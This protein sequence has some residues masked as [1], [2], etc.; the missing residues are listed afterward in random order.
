[1]VLNQSTVSIQEYGRTWVSVVHDG[2]LRLTIIRPRV[3]FSPT[4]ALFGRSVV[5]PDRASKRR[6]PSLQGSLKLCFSDFGSGERMTS[7]SGS[8][9]LRSMFT[10]Y[11]AQISSAWRMRAASASAKASSFG[12][13]DKAGFAMT[14]ARPLINSRLISIAF[15]SSGSSAS[16]VLEGPD[17]TD[18]ADV[19]TLRAEEGVEVETLGMIELDRHGFV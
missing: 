1:M 11:L 19:D 5:Q 16:F 4:R 7:R 8:S 15:S 14:R 17:G 3:S 9:H 6:I 18:L 13:S 2:D 10:S 12:A